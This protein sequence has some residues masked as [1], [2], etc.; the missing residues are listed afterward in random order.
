[1]PICMGANTWWWTV[2]T[3]ISSLPCCTKSL[4]MY[5]FL[6]WGWLIAGNKLHAFHVSLAAQTSLVNLLKDLPSSGSDFT[7]VQEGM[8]QMS[9]RWNW[10]VRCPPENHI[11]KMVQLKIGIF[12]ELLRW[13]KSHSK[14]T[15]PCPHTES[16]LDGVNF[17]HSRPYGAFWICALTAGDHTSVFGY[18]WMPAGHQAN[19]YCFHSVLPESQLE[20]SNRVEGVTARTADLNWSKK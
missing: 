9:F 12:M 18:C 11:Q 4:R 7:L 3:R 13:D 8:N 15:I 17:P 19:A 10:D 16:D 1:M 20:V 6:A 2:A 5:E 14:V